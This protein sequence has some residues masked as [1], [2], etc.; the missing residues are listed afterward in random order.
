MREKK[1]SIPLLIFRL[2]I[3][4]DRHDDEP[5]G[6]AELGPLYQNQ[7]E[8]PEVRAIMDKVFWENDQLPDLPEVE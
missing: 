6:P 3:A 4:D 8:D 2:T 5:F 7:E 1:Y